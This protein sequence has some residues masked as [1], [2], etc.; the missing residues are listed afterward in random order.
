MFDPPFIFKIQKDIYGYDII[1]TEA[2]FKV[3]GC[4]DGGRG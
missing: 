2:C 3:M 4:R 1:L